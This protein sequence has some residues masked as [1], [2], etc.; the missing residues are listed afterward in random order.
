MEQNLPNNHDSEANTLKRRTTAKIIERFLVHVFDC[1]KHYD[2]DSDTPEPP[3]LIAL[4]QEVERILSAK[5]YWYSTIVDPN[6]RAI[7]N[8]AVEPNGRVKVVIGTTEIV[9]GETPIESFQSEILISALILLNRLKEYHPKQ[10]WKSDPCKFF[11]AA[12]EISAGLWS[13]DIYERVH[14]VRCSAF[15]LVD[16]AEMLH[17]EINLCR[18]LH[19]DLRMDLETLWNFRRALIEDFAS[20]ERGPSRSYPI[21]TRT[22]PHPVVCASPRT[23]TFQSMVTHRAYY[24]NRPVQAIDGHSWD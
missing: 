10:S 6:D 21:R 11:V 1:P 3:Q 13:G 19:W 15:A 5:L 18:D 9:E 12:L 4:Y 14:H 16:P 22:A 8:E 2:R 20:K 17:F 7:S 24:K 23:Q